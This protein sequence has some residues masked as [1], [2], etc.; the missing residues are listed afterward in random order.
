MHTDGSSAKVEQADKFMHKKC[1]VNAG[2]TVALSVLTALI[3]APL[4][5]GAAATAP[6]AALGWWTDAK[7]WGF[8]GAIA[9]WGMS[10]A[11]IKDAATSGPEIISPNMTFV[12]L[13][14]S[15]LFAWWAWVVNPQNLLLCACHTAN[16]LAQG[17]QA[18]RLV[19]FSL[20]EGKGEEVNKM[21]K[22][23][24]AVII[25]GVAAIFGGP[26]LQGAVAGAGLGMLSTIAAAPAGPFTVHFW[27]PMS[28]W[29]ISGASFLDLQR[30]TDKI[31]IA[32]YTALTLTGLF[33]TRYALLVNPINYILCSVN[34]ALFL[35]SAWQLGR[36]IKADYL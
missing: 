13:I 1:K 16:V 9:G 35:S 2:K 18:R 3:V 21:A 33:F 30:P 14:Y 11:A 10:L 8:L 36:K 27:A 29:L 32:Q 19:K 15:G 5:A 12:M 34:I 28:K 25:A 31:S 4:A 22:N 24:I 23:A 7:F 6:A 17:N 26:T 20:A